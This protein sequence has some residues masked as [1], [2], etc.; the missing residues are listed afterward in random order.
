MSDS[1]VTIGESVVQHG[2]ENDRVY[3]MKLS[4]NDMPDMMSQINNLAH[5]FG[6]TKVF[7]KV[8]PFAHDAFRHDGYV[9]EARIPQFFNTEADG[10]FMSKFLSSQRRQDAYVSAENSV[11]E[12]ALGKTEEAPP[13]LNA[14]FTAKQLSV[15]DVERM[16]A[17]YKKVFETYPFPIHN[18][19]YLI[20][21]MADNV[22]YFGVWHY[23]NLVAVSSCEVSREGANAEMTDFAVLHQFRGKKLASYLLDLMEKHLQTIDIHTAYTIAR[24]KSFGMNVTFSKAG[25]TFAGKLVNNTNISGHIESMNVWYKRI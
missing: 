11:L 19:N 12:T 15:D 25:Y 2:K 6:Y 13:R 10:Y 7:A 17:L 20:E 24:A 9:V 23:N 5:D 18:R 1:V 8:P 22:E 16:A 14:E 21:T 3:V 4:K